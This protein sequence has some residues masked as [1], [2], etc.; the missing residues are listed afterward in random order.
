MYPLEFFNEK[1]NNKVKKFE[2]IYK[3]SCEKIDNKMDLL[4]ITWC[5]EWSGTPSPPPLFHI[6]RDCQADNTLLHCNL[7]LL[8]IFFVMNTKKIG[9]FLFRSHDNLFINLGTFIFKKRDSRIHVCEFSL[10]DSLVILCANYSKC[11]TYIYILCFLLWIF[12]NSI[13]WII[14]WKLNMFIQCNIYYYLVIF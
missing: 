7:L 14:L 10:F 4:G 12:N 11:H 3:T 6:G 5:P 8:I 2:Q 13:V 9:H 1:N